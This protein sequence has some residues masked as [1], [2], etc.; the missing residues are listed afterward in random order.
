MLSGRACGAIAAV[1]SALVLGPGGAAYGSV[2]AHE[3]GAAAAAGS[4]GEAGAVGADGAADEAGAAIEDRYLLL[5]GSG[6]ILGAA[7]GEV[8]GVAGGFAQTFLDGSIYWSAATGAHAV[9]GDVDR[10]YRALGGPASAWGLPT[11]EE[12]AG[13]IATARQNAF[14]GGV[15]IWSAR[16]GA[17]GVRGPIL[18]RWAALGGGTVSS[19]SLPTG[20][21]EAVSDDGLRGFFQGGEIIWSPATGAWRVYGANLAEF[22]RLGGPQGAGF[23]VDEEAP[24]P[25]G[26]AQAFERSRIYWSASTGSH[27]LFGD[28]LRRY[29]DL[30]GPASPLGLPSTSEV[31]VPGGTRAMFNGGQIVWASPQGAKALLGDLHRR[32]ESLGG[33]WSPLGLPTTE[34]YDVVPDRQ[35][36]FAGGALRWVR[37]TGAINLIIPFRAVVHPV[38]AAELPFS[39]RSGCPVGPASLRRLE[40]SY[41]DFAGSPQIGNLIIVH[42]AVAVVTRAF[43]RS[44]AAGFPIQRMA[45]VD[46][47]G[48][49]DVAS[50]AAGNTSAFNCRKVVGNPYRISQHSYGNAVDINPAQNPYVYGGVVYPAGSRTYLNRRVHRQGMH[51]SGTAVLDTMRAEGWSW[52]ARWSEPDYHHFS[53]NGG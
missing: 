15:I 42:S 11:S 19:L 7:S 10:R 14:V 45:S 30:G 4:A 35:V 17:H 9:H 29:L 3:T 33:P 49:N 51:V 40:V 1:C 21:T 39:Y 48:G 50:M 46:A 25:A 5:G 52:G 12:T 18:D 6:G 32:Y 44:F 28:V 13:E 41:L 26:V 16:T 53:S 27:G 2:A 8:H 36:D 47:Y 34:E 24:V 31:A 23:P 22:A 37:Q 43:E 38:S 20:S